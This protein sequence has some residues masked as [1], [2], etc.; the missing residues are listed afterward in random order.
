[1]LSFSFSSFGATTAA[2][3]LKIHFI[4]VGQAD[5]ILVQTNGNYMLIDTGNNGDSKTIVN[6]LKKLGVKKLEFLLLTHPHEDHI[7]CAGVIIKTFQ[8]GKV[9]MPKVSTTTKTFENVLTSLKAKNLKVTTPVAGSKFTLNKAEFTILAPNSSKYEDLNNYSIVMK[10][11]FGKNSFIFTGDAE[12]LS[13][14]EIIK[15]RYNVKADFIK[16]GHHG[17]SSSTSAAFLKAVSPKYAVVSVGKDNDYNHPHK[18][19]MDIL[20]N[21]GIKL[22]RTDESGTII[23]TSDGKNLSFNCKAGTYSYRDT[24][25]VTP[26]PTA[27]PSSTNTVTVTPSPTA[28]PSPA[29]TVTVTPSPTVNSS[30]TNTVDNRIVYYTAGGKSYHY[31]K[32]CPTLSR[33]KNILEGKLQDV[34]NM[35]KSDPCDKCVK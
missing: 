1:M 20:K 5:S 27:N 26:S 19:T 13:E 8:I 35:G 15:K 29:N 4:D 28:N 25:A 10:L 34:I 14:S 3:Q 23:C 31:N 6:Y 9:Y 7:G 30:S 32:G 12:A 21:A 2:D 11:V 22:Y 24:V 18:V 16:I 17:S 33:S